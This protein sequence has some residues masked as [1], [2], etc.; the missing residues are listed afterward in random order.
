MKF[1]MIFVAKEVCAPG[2]IK[3][4][5]NNAEVI[6]EVRLHLNEYEFWIDDVKGI[7]PRKMSGSEKKMFLDN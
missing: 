7:R 3:K 5:N 2:R 6:L 1:I 4:I